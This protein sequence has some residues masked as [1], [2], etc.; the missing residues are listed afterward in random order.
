M[1]RRLIPLCALVLLALA[2]FVGPGYESFAAPDQQTPSLPQADDPPA[3]VL[4]DGVEGL[5]LVS[6]PVTLPLTVGHITYL[7]VE[8][9]SPSAAKYRFTL[10]SMI[11]PLS[12]PPKP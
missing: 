6:A 11:R 2:A 9:R 1:N 8:V 4:A 3:I 7:P 10:M 5:T 12:R